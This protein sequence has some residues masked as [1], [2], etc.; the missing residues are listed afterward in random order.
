MSAPPKHKWK[1]IVTGSSFVNGLRVI[2]YKWTCENCALE[3]TTQYG[4]LFRD[5]DEFA[6]ECISRQV[7]QV[8]ES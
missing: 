6:Y 8:M 4:T 3:L 1:T 2:D 5:Q 7:Q